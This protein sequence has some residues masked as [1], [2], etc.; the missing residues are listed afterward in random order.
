MCLLLCYIRASPTG[1]LNR[2]LTLFFEARQKNS[3]STGPQLKSL[4][5]GGPKIFLLSPISHGYVGSSLLYD[6]KFF[7]LPRN[8]FSPLAR[9][10]PSRTAAF[11]LFVCN[12]LSLLDPLYVSAAF[13]RAD[14]AA[15]TYSISHLSEILASIRTFRLTRDCASDRVAMQAHLSCRPGGLVAMSTAPSSALRPPP[16][17]DAPSHRR[18]V[19]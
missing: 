10:T 8:N 11:N 14:L 3:S 7:S 5:Y 1:T 15:A 12:Y 19:E 17:W 18:L 6:W 16:R 13:G 4:L 2:A 9:P